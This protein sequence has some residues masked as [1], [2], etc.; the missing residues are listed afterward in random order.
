MK[1]IIFYSVLSLLTVVSCGKDDDVSEQGGVPGGTIDVSFKDWLIPKDEIKDGGPGKDGIPSIDNPVFLDQSDFR[2]SFLQDD[3]L[4]VGIYKNG[5][6]RA[7]PH[8]IL[9]WHEIVNDVIDDEPVTISYC[10][11]TGTA[12]GWS[13]ESNM[14]KS[15]F[16][17]SGL[18]YNAN[19]ILYD[20]NTD[21]N[22]SQL[23]LECV[24]GPQMGDK[25]VIV[26]IVETTWKTWRTLYPETTVLSLD[27]GFSRSYGTYPYGP[28]KTNDQYF[29]FQVTPL[30][31][32]LPNK[33]RIHAVIDEGISKVY[34]FVSFGAGKAYKD[35]FNNKDLLVVGNED[36]IVSF[37]LA[38]DQL[39]LEFE[40]DMTETG[41]LF[42][43]NEGNKWSL[44]GKAI[45]G[46]RLGEQLKGTTSVASYWFAIA[47]FYP[48]PEIF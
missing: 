37:E 19:L 47:A 1:K 48:E 41:V 32:A 9:D 36:L 8:S 31:E 22:W 46:P 27:T 14:E 2:T 45:E 38:D 23:R 26:D 15:T 18:L 21:S 20:R 17:V 10:P 35:I 6:S 4:V 42:T 24:N 39:N 33:L 30:N 28:Y 34:R 7:Y 44:F 3:D 43:D 29:V 12:F 11:L 5:V 40:Y 25:P 13:S 16:G